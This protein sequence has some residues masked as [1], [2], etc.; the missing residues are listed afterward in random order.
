MSALKR[1]VTSILN[2]FKLLKGD[3]IVDNHPSFAFVTDNMTM[4]SVDGYQIVIY[5]QKKRVLQKFERWYMPD[6]PKNKYRVFSVASQSAPEALKQAC[7][8]ELC[9]DHLFPDTPNDFVQKETVIATY[10]DSL[11]KRIRMEPQAA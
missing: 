6:L 3:Y 11:L 5:C 10:L 2:L 8:M 7:Q 9:V 4:H 1:A